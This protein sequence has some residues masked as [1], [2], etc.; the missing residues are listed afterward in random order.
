MPKKKAQKAK[1]KSA[2]VSAAQIKALRDKVDALHDWATLM[3]ANWTSP[4]QGWMEDEKREGKKKPG[5]MVPLALAGTKPPPPP[6]P[7]P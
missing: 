6:P 4:S 3:Y 2:Q 5:T 1:A 7:Y